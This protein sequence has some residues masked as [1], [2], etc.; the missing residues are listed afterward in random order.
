[1]SYRGMVFKASRAQ[2][3]SGIKVYERL[4]RGEAGPENGSST[5]RVM[6]QAL[7]GDDTWTEHDG[8]IG[9]TVLP[10]QVRDA[11]FA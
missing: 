3:L 10:G 7:R 8:H 11:G 4:P 2:A 9:P 1:M 6:E 5:W